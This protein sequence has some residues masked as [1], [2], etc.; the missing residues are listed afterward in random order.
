[1]GN[2]GELAVRCGDG[3]IAESSHGVLKVAGVRGRWNNC[4]PCEENSLEDV[5]VALGG[6]AAL[7]S[8]GTN[9]RSCR[10]GRAQMSGNQRE[11]KF[12]REAI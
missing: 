1:M 4:A 3:T 2:G 8:V 5:L 9:D 10:A 6:A 12:T 7:T 11:A